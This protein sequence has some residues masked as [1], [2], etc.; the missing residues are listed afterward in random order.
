MYERWRA[1]YEVDLRAKLPIMLRNRDK[2]A[3]RQQSEVPRLQLYDLLGRDLISVLETLILL[4]ACQI[5]VRTTGLQRALQWASR[6][7]HKSTKELSGNSAQRVEHIARIVRA[8]C[9]RWPLH[10]TCLDRGIASVIVLGRRGASVTL[11]MGFRTWRCGIEG[12]A[13]VEYEGRALAEVGDVRQTYSR[14]VLIQSNR[15]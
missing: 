15:V 2:V 11:C 6:V 5:A 7:A 9:W 13:W 3:I 8:T 12:H 4:P 14:Q 10:A 1:I